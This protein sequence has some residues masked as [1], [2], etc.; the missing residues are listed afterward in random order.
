M[1]VEEE[2]NDRVNVEDFYRTDQKNTP[3]Y[4]CGMCIVHLPHHY[5]NHITGK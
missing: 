2:E 5:H 1:T 3:S 4:V